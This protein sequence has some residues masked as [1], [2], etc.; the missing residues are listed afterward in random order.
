[1]KEDYPTSR[2]FLVNL[3]R[4]VFTVLKDGFVFVL[5]LLLLHFTEHLNNRIGAG[6][7]YPSV[8]TRP[9]VT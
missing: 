4:V 3:R 2:C 5:L 1:M 8:P 7:G 9:I 6:I